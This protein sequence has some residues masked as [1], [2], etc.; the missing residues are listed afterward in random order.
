MK[1][2]KTRV[3]VVSANLAAAPAQTGELTGF[4][5]SIRY[6]RHADAARAFDDT[7]DF[8]ITNNVTGEVVLNVDNITATT[9]WYPRPSLQSTAATPL[10]YAAG[11]E[12][13]PSEQGFCLFRENLDIA[14]VGPG[15]L[16]SGIIEIMMVVE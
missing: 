8:D 16:K 13:I 6:I 2:E 15:T 1:I 10:V 3:T 12:E 5:H 14:V 7:V 11:G 9:T 4:I